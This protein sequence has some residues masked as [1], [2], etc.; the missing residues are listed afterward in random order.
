MKNLFNM[1]NMKWSS[2]DNFY[3]LRF[4]KIVFRKKETYPFS[5]HGF[6]RLVPLDYIF[7]QEN[8]SAVFYLFSFMFR[9]MAAYSKCLEPLKIVMWK[10]N[11]NFMQKYFL[12]GR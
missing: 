8:Y 5:S 9:F 11:N 7:I 4:A 10:N 1:L 12:H 2:F 6:L 3:L